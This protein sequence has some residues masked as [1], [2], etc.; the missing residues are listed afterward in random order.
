MHGTSDTLYLGA[1]VAD[2]AVAA[3]D[4]TDTTNV[5][6]LAQSARYNSTTDA[7]TGFSRLGSTRY[8]L[9]SDGEFSVAG[10]M[11]DVVA[12]ADRLGRSRA[13]LV[14]LPPASGADAIVA[15]AN[16]GLRLHA[17]NLQSGTFEGGIVAADRDDI[18]NSATF[19][20]FTFT[21]TR[22]TSGGTSSGL[23]ITAF[24]GTLGF[25]GGTFTIPNLNVNSANGRFT[26]NTASY[27][28]STGA[29]P[30]SVTVNGFFNGPNANLVSAIWYTADNATIGAFV[31]R[32]RTVK[33]S[34]HISRS[35]GPIFYHRK[36]FADFSGFGSGDSSEQQGLRAL[37]LLPSIWDHIND[38]A[39]DFDESDF[40]SLI[41]TLLSTNSA[42]IT[43]TERSDITVLSES[44]ASHT[45]AK[46]YSG[47]FKVREDPTWT[48]P[49][50]ILLADH[51]DTWAIL[52]NPSAGDDFALATGRRAALDYSGLK[53][54]GTGTMA[55]IG[56][57]AYVGTFTTG[58]KDTLSQAAFGSFVMR[59]RFHE[60]GSAAQATI[61]EFR[62]AANGNTLTVAAGVLLDNT[63]TF[64]SAGNAQYTAKGADS[65]VPATIQGALFGSTNRSAA[66]IWYTNETIPMNAG[67]FVGDN[68]SFEE[69]K[70]IAMNYTLVTGVVSTSGKAAEVIYLSRRQTGD[71]A[72]QNRGNNNRS[73]L[74]RDVA[75]IVPDSFTLSAHPSNIYPPSPVNGVTVSR[76]D[77]GTTN[78]YMIDGNTS[79][80]IEIDSHNVGLYVVQISK[81]DAPE[82]SYNKPF[83]AIAHSPVSGSR[84][85]SY[86]YQGR[87]TYNANGGIAGL[88]QSTSEIGG[89]GT[90]R[91]SANFSNSTF[92]FA[93]YS[94]FNANIANGTISGDG[95][96]TLSNGRLFASNVFINGP[97][98]QFTN[99]EIYGLFGGSDYEGLAGVYYYEI[100]LPNLSPSQAAIINGVNF[101]GFVG[102][103]LG[104]NSFTRQG[105]VFTDNGGI[106][107]GTATDTTGVPNVVTSASILS[108]NIDAVAVNATGGAKGAFS[109]LVA[110]LPDQFGAFTTVSGQPFEVITHV[111]GSVY[112]DKNFVSVKRWANGDTNMYLT[113]PISGGDSALVWGPAFGSAQHGRYSYVGV[114]VGG[115]RLTMFG[116]VA[117]T[118]NLVANFT[119]GG[120]TVESYSGTAGGRTL[121]FSGTPTTI[122]ASTGRFNITNATYVA[123]GTT[124]ATSIFGA[125]HGSTGGAI[126]GLWRTNDTAN[127]N[128]G[129]FIGGRLSFR[130]RLVATFQYRGQYTP[131]VVEAESAFDRTRV[132]YNGQRSNSYISEANAATIAE[133]DFAFMLD[134]DTV[135][136]AAAS[137]LINGVG[138]VTVATDHTFRGRSIGITGYEIASHNAGAYIGRH[139][140]SGPVAEQR[141]FF[142]TVSKHLTDSASLTGIYLYHGR[143]LSVAAATLINDSTKIA[144][145]GFRMTV[146][147]ASSSSGVNPIF[148]LSGRSNSD[149]AALGNVTLFGSGEVLNTASG[150]FRSTAMTIGNFPTA[151]LSTE[152]LGPQTTSTGRLQGY[153]AGPGGQALVGWFVGTQLGSGAAAATTTGVLVGER[154]AILE[155]E[156]RIGTGISGPAGGSLSITQVNSS[157]TSAAT[158]TSVLFA[159]PNYQNA[160]AGGAT[161]P[162]VDL[163]TVDESGLTHN[164][165]RPGIIAY[166][167]GT[168]TLDG[169]QGELGR[170]SGYPSPASGRMYFLEFEPQTAG[171]ADPIFI[172]RGNSATDIPATGVQKYVGSLV[173]RVKGSSADAA[174]V[175][176][177]I[178]V[179][180]GTGKFSNFSANLG[181]ANGGNITAQGNVSVSNGTFI[182]VDPSP[183]NA[184]DI[185][186]S[187]RFFDA[188]AGGIGGVWT[189]I[190]SAAT[191]K[192]FGAFIGSKDDASRYPFTR[193]NLS[194]EKSDIDGAGGT[195]YGVATG[196]GSRLASSQAAGTASEYI[197]VSSTIALD[198]STASGNGG[199]DLAWLKQARDRALSADSSRG[200]YVL[201][202][203]GF[204]SHDRMTKTRGLTSADGNV[205]AYETTKADT[206]VATM[207]FIDNA[208]SDRIVVAGPEYTTTSL[209]AIRQSRSSGVD[210]F[211]YVGRMTMPKPLNVAH[212]LQ[213]TETLPFQLTLSLGETE[214][215]ANFSVAAATLAIDNTPQNVTKYVLSIPTGASSIDFATGKLTISDGADGFRSGIGR[216]TPN[217]SSPKVFQSDTFGFVGQIFGDK[218][219]AVGG[220]YWGL[221]DKAVQDIPDNMHGQPYGGA[222]VGTR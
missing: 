48:V 60:Q 9:R 105:S 68:Q 200:D 26:T 176:F 193:F 201:S 198:V 42:T 204:L 143:Y 56:D 1:L 174:V 222:F 19:G 29:S 116:A 8:A 167:S 77:F 14:D 17:L 107:S 150:M 75:N 122:N 31:G 192:R 67:V 104:E 125:F 214:A 175:P 157:G 64:F 3:N 10:G 183:G 168:V 182:S 144:S 24:S 213:S 188:N 202:F 210:E 23:R 34:E 179:N 218:A 209:N 16:R 130:N 85:G 96:I 50:K 89:Y 221:G 79:R 220:V 199:G 170:L 72:L 197:V 80:A 49:A 114:H 131:G 127:A 147:F 117:G 54:S 121:S 59:I 99:G 166:S 53:A 212:A 91:L 103:R 43:G 159:V 65:G 46:L 97:A 15:T 70:R 123:Q 108:P 22:Q 25:S 184:D 101:G 6:N 2:N 178:D 171:A 83:I 208:A 33:A 169:L 185:A 187:G 102:E 191:S 84:T 211:V 126:Y 21:P 90:F 152:P 181:T 52:G 162:L 155:F 4:S 154:A 124:M 88:K 203:Y 93:G 98:G 78:S 133:M 36:I 61:R 32:S 39:T 86:V 115:P 195:T 37:F 111:T 142:L 81:T 76:F 45:N 87:H 41:S 109:R 206:S 216:R 160:L 177:S 74:L 82:S 63:T 12:I 149:D 141:D 94:S 5:I 40:D 137:D 180:F 134:E 73:K 51:D 196:E 35:M 217:A 95:V 153:L 44:T 110:L 106:A 161:H 190:N 30:K 129:A 128:A 140:S 11:R 55:R 207:Y 136:D 163:V 100:N 219:D 132:I 173:H 18:I 118:F 194:I 120:S 205:V 148:Y 62:A 20:D 186:I 151:S 215:Q 66:G 28:A 113:N 7:F 69:I 57:W 13:F 156:G 145:V 92:K 71:D 189:T 164:G 172:V 138:E 165:F 58:A 112:I 47:N 139:N 119:T 158:A 135:D 27:L 146:D 38:V